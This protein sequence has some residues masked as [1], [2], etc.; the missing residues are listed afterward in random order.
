M[1]KLKELNAIFLFQQNEIIRK[2]AFGYS[3]SFGNKASSTVKSET[4]NICR[5]N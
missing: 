2:P 4:M 1:Q 5:N 3:C